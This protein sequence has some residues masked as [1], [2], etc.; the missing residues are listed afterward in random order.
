MR[1]ARH[2]AQASYKIY[3][4]WATLY[5]N[6]NDLSEMCVP[7]SRHHLLRDFKKKYE[8]ESLEGSQK[9]FSHVFKFLFLVLSIV[10][11]KKVKI[12]NTKKKKFKLNFL[13]NERDT[14][15]WKKAIRKLFHSR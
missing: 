14:K 15:K 9:S 7:Y 8:I 6:K 4:N 3:E 10:K 1:S 2:K 11:D 12:D 13:K 5:A